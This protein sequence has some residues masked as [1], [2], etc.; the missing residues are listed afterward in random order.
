M[1]E[2]TTEYNSNNDVILLE[3]QEELRKQSKIIKGLNSFVNFMYFIIIFKVIFFSV[4]IYLLA[5]GTIDIL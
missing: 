1:E 2:Q 5:V 4:I 3:I